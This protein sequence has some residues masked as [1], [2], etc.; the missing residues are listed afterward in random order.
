VSE[1]G[2]DPSGDELKIAVLIVAYNAASTLRSVLDRIPD[3]FRRR[4]SAVYVSDDA[5][6][7][8][9]YLVG[10]G[11]QTLTDLPLK[12]VRHQ[13]N[14]GYGGNQKA[15][16]QMAMADGM[17]IVVL[18]HG[19]GQY[20]PELLGD[21]VAPLERGD[22]D[23][24]F[25][26]RM[27]DPGSARRGGMPMYKYVGNR[28]L[29]HFENAVLGTD[30]SEFHS[31]YR[32][33]SV[34]ALRTLDLNS[35]SD[36]FDFDTE[37]IIQFVESG[38][39]IHEIPIPTYYGDEI[40]RVN[41]LRYAWDVA[42]DVV[43]WRLNRMGFG[44]GRL[45][46][47]ADE[48]EL[49]ADPHSSHGRILDW[50]AAAPRGRVLDLG[51]SSG[52]LS[53]R[54]RALGH[55]VTAVDMYTHADV[56]TRCDEFHQFD[57]D[58]GLPMVL[59]DGSYDTVILADVVE[60]VRNPEAVLRTAAEALAPGG[61]MVIS[62]PNFGHWYPRLRTVLGMFDYD[63]RGIIDRTHLRF[64]T[65][66][67]FRKMLDRCGLA[68][69]RLEAVGLPIDAL[70]DGT[71]GPLK[72]LLLRIE[73]MAA[74]TRPTLFGYQFVAKVEPTRLSPVTNQGIKEL[75][76]SDEISLSDRVAD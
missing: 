28:I 53:E 19:D 3:A 65:R 52:L 14:L 71:R 67:S 25:G 22:A 20:A 26:S 39:R 34:A 59:R 47:P 33:Y 43:T 38:F 10:L 66:R 58:Q 40:C 17:D 30:L 35:N 16:Y 24:V 13:A 62:V 23:A 50:A 6:D 46:R 31:G 45:A 8:A 74:T 4:V 51:A 63:N 75:G 1:A 15:G 69:I 76:H 29:T 60:H 37:I 70:D 36:D 48:Y 18:L 73:R 57:L 55:H 2:Q 68:V 42:V 56:A 61:A 7:D 11:Y 44:E 21:M 12:V 5:S 32:A 72:R 49:K 41:G 54:I 27:I 64:F 9:T